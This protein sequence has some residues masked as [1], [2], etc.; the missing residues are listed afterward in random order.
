M[1][2]VII[3]MYVEGKWRKVADFGVYG[4]NYGAGYHA[5]CRLS[6]DFDYVLARMAEDRIVDR[7][8]CR[9][10]INFDS[11]EG[12]S[13]PAFL[14]DLL[15]TGAARGAWLK[16]LGIRDDASSW[17]QLLRFA[18]GNPPGN[19]RIAGASVEAKEHSGFEKEKIIEKNVDFIEYAEA[20][21]A[22]VA[23]ASDVQGQAPK[24][25]LVE[26]HRDRWH[27]EG[28]IPEDQVKCHW[29]VKFP[30]GKTDADRLVLRNE[31]PYYEVA[32]AF[33]LRAAA[34]LEYQDDALFVRRFD[35]R[36]TQGGVERFGLESMT[37]VCGISEFG[38]R[39][40]H[41]EAC[42]MIHRYT[43]EPRR[44][45]REYIKRDILNVALRNTDN[46][47]R[48]TA[49]LKSPS[50]VIALSPLFDFAPMFKD[51]EGIARVYRWDADGE[52]EIGL[53][54][55]GHV[56][57]ALEKETEFTGKELRH[58]LADCSPEVENLPE[59]MARCGVEENL[60]DDLSRR[61]QQVA[62]KLKEARPP[63]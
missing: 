24:F 37:S 26:D 9:Y 21:G 46:H 61:I 3:E 44:E 39:G 11:Y 59:T 17:W 56:A 53:P 7:V 13:W 27:A 2:E 14:L 49:F 54:D 63:M 48:N 40:S 10:P 22:L 31:A 19:L 45:I 18:T 33:G 52:K 47:G 51:P 34:P 35:R 32:R 43:T 6:Y 60:V 28:A 15:P 12:N 25:L 4:K 23:G 36:V 5:K 62:R 8:G 29:M 38:L 41:N 1:D 42:K 20:N 58:W 16:T 30:R 55:W 50:G 57:E